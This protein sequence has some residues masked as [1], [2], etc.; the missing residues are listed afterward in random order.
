MCPFLKTVIPESIWA[1]YRCLIVHPG[2]KGDRGPSSLDWAIELGAPTWGVTVL[3]ANGDLDAGEVWATRSFPMRRAGKSSLYRHEVRH[4]AIEA[5][6]EATG[7]I[8]ARGAVV[9]APDSERTAETGRARPLMTQ[10]FR[11]IDWD[12]DCTDTVLRKIRAGEGHPGV[13]DSIHGTEFHLFGAH[14]ERI[15]RGRCG[16]TDRTARRRDLSS[17]RR[18]RDLDHPPQA[19]RHPDTSVLQAAFRMRAGA[20]RP[21]PGPAGELGRRA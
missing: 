14:R 5:L 21:R 2:P 3:E 10:D 20:R 7:K 15:L 11:A 13:L 18:R 8:A 6:I 12:S 16:R 4:A 9:D 1:K 17:D 19:P